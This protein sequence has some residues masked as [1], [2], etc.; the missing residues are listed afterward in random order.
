MDRLDFSILLRRAWL[1]VVIMIAGAAAAYF[2]TNSRPVT[3]EAQA[4][5]MVGPGIESPNPDLNVLR[6]GGQLIQMYAELPLTE[7]FLENIIQTTKQDMD[8][9]E[10]ADLIEMR[11]NQ[12]T[13]ILTVQVRHADANE[14]IDIANA[15]A[16]Q[17]VK[18]SPSNPESTAAVIKDHVYTQAFEL[19]R[20]IQNSKEKIRQ[21]ESDYQ[22]SIAAE[23]MARE[24]AGSNKYVV[25]Q[26]RQFEQYKNSIGNATQQQTVGIKILQELVI[27]SNA[28]LLQFEKELEGV[29][30]TTTQKLIREQIRLERNHLSQLQLAIAEIEHPVEGLPLDEHIASIQARIDQ[31]E[32][33]LTTLLNID[34]RRIQYDQINQEQ[35]RLSRA[36]QIESERQKRILDMIAA[37]RERVSQIELAEIEKKRL[38]LEQISSERELLAGTENTLA[39]LYNSIREADPNQVRI[40]E[41]ASYAIPLTPPISL[42]IIIGAMAAL[43]LGAFAVIALEYFSGELHTSAQVQKVLPGLVIDTQ[44]PGAQPV[45]L[46]QGKPRT[47]LYRQKYRTLGLHLVYGQNEKGI[48]FIVVSGANERVPSGLAAISLAITLSQAGKNVLLIET[49]HAHPIISSFFQLHGHDGW[50]DFLSNKGFTHPTLAAVDHFPNLLVLPYGNTL[51]DPSQLASRKML[52]QLLLLQEQADVVICSLPDLNKPEAITLTTRATGVI[53]VV[54]KDITTQGEL[55]EAAKNLALVGAN[56]LATVIEPKHASVF[57]KAWNEEI[58]KYGSLQPAFEEQPVINPIISPEVES[59]EELTTTYSS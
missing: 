37:E 28:R 3:Y 16:N 41:S 8:P 52:S 43:G 13:Q 58:E 36:H 15:V 38:I 46:F 53:L 20:S 24:E 54:Q 19:E 27:N 31:L 4:R 7:P 21:L 35:E 50:S 51:I 57:Q 32:Q 30:N 33:Q 44:D 26:L 18:I 11:A 56:I 45:P 17:L 6:A 14:A 9:Q 5:L 55:S 25:E 12:E 49:D 34:L 40:I 48:R 23:Q 42:A 39:M 59:S 10:M 2:F 47:E 22:K 1:L 29:T